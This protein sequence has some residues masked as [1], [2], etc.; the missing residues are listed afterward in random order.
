MK[1]LAPIILFTY[2]RPTNT[3]RT[4][5]HLQRNKFATESD[6]IIYSD[7]PKNRDAEKGVQETR[8]Y[9]KTIKGFRSVQII[10]RD[11]NFGL[12]VNIME[13]VGETVDKYG[14]VIV[15][16][17][18]LDTSPYFLQFMNE[19]LTMYENDE[20]V[21]AVHGY[22]PPT[23]TKLPETFFM[24]DTGCLG[25]ATWKRGWALFNPDSKTLLKQ[26]KASKMTYQFD[27]H[28]TYPFTDLLEIQAR[29]DS[30][31]W[32]IRWYASAFLNEKLTLYP[33][34]S[35]VVHK[36]YDAGTHCNEIPKWAEKETYSE[37]PIKVEKIG[38]KE[39]E[40]ARQ[41]IEDF[42]RATQPGKIHRIAVR[43]LRRMKLYDF[44]RNLKKTYSV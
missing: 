42:Y 13:G 19:A 39:S 17:D 37:T 14:K 12:A 24:N 23:D 33:G 18:D 20:K 34:R 28:G 44:F 3:K 2:N 4:V 31:S 35:L 1:N 6:L 10:E 22:F 5:E 32:A 9:L 7:A 26:V 11:R 15:V 30:T 36:G 43:Y 27:Y 29:G 38:I 16:E 21:I 40:V 25:W 8:K 41:A